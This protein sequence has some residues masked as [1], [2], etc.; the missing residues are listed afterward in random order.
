MQK[1][2]NDPDISYTT[3]A[4]RRSAEEVLAHWDVD[5]EE[6]LSTQE[7]ETRRKRYGPNRLSTARRK[8]NWHIL[9]SQ[10]KSLVVI[11]LLVAACTAAAFGQIIEA[12]AIGSALIINAA[13]GFGTEYAATR[14]MDALRR[15]GQIV[16]RVRRAGKHKSLRAEMLVPGDI[17]LLREGDVVPADL[18]LLSVENLQCDESALTGE[19][20]PVNKTADRLPDAEAP[21]AERASMAFKATAVTRGAGEGVVVRSGTSTEIG[22]IS[23]LV[24]AAS[25]QSAPLERRLERLGHRLI[26][27]VIALGAAVAALGILAGKELFLMIETAIVLAIAAVPEGLPVVS[28][29]SLGR[30]MWR[31]ARRNALVKRLSA[32]ETLGATT[33]I[34]TDKT[35][36]LTEN[37]MV[38]R[39]LALGAGDVEL[40][41]KAQEFRAVDQSLD[42]TERPD[43]IAALRAG[44]LCNNAETQDGHTSGDP[45]EVA[46]LEAGAIGDLH[47]DELLDRFSEEREVSFDA[48]TKMMATY[49]R[50]ENGYLVAVK[51]A[52]EAVLDAATRVRCGDEERDLD[53]R[54]HGAW[55]ERNEALAAGGLR[56]LAV[57]EKA[58]EEKTADP[59]EDLTLLGL[60]GL[61]DPPRAT[62]ADAIRACRDAGIRVVMVTGDQAAT[63]LNVGREVAIVDREEA[64]SEEAYVVEGTDISS[65]DAE[66]IK[67]V[68]IFARVS[69]E[70]KLTLVEAFQQAGEIVGMTG[71]GVN[72]APALKKADIG[73]AMGKRGTDVA[74]DA[75]DIVLKDDAFETIVMAIRQG[76]TIFVNIRAFVVFLLSGNLGQIIAISFAALAGA[77]LPLLPLQIL[78]L[79][80][81]LDVFPALALGL[82]EDEPAIMRRPPRD[83]NE[84]ILTRNHW[85]AI[86]G[87]GVL[88]GASVL[89]VF[90]VALVLLEMEPAAAVTVSFLTYAFAR[91]WHLFNMR[92]LDSHLLDNSVTRSRYVWAA[93]GLCLM[94]IFLSLFVPAAASLLHL[95]ALTGQ[96]WLVVLVG[97]ALPFIVGQISI[98]VVQ[99]WQ[100]RA[101]PAPAAA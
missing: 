1:G 30:G 9:L 15:I 97:S 57:A 72:D 85:L 46:L 33:V 78:F 37:H 34:L 38:L 95:S 28:T 89:G 16:A 74:R 86:G 70:D 14:S 43:F 90:A 52:P 23:E 56:V 63:A 20:Q 18:R 2:G 68:A 47:R 92:S 49:H 42:P 29:L 64:E 12:V 54:A 48:E 39:R 11:L 60:I 58:V 4:Y 17:V 51:G 88:I 83:P 3:E 81:L 96:Q 73:I 5:C 19:S 66:R 53:E 13:V 7:A 65:K 27:L 91:L 99:R 82:G 75:S 10:F 21:L 55:Q 6:G 25:D 69:P 32:V 31:M 80:L 35:G 76:R 71:D 67:R 26:F 50:V 61:Y 77:P 101:R 36:T 87:F 45:M 84:P 24:E 40:S 44:V 22:R 100:R 98:E 62:V 79:N 59:Y 41:R 94:L 8:S 93:I